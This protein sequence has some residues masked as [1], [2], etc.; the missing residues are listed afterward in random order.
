MISIESAY[1]I[2][3]LSQR[4]RCETELM[5]LTAAGH[6]Y[7]TTGSGRHFN[8]PGN[9]VRLVGSPTVPYVPVAQALIR[10]WAIADGPGSSSSGF[11]PSRAR[12]TSLRWNQRTSA[13]SSSSITMS[14]LAASA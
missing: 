13:I 6:P 9:G 12:R 3:M 5:R 11:L 14:V 7:E 2:F 1:T 10:W 4:Q 8:F